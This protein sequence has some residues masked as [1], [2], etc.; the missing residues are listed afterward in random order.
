VTYALLGLRE[1]KQAEDERRCWALTT[2]P[3]ITMKLVFVILLTFVPATA[4]TLRQDADRAGVF[5]SAAVRPSQFNEVAYASTLAREFNMLEPEN[6]LKWSALRPDEKTF[7]F[8]Q[9]DQAVGF[10]RVHGMKVRGHTLVWGWWNPAWLT[11]HP[12]SPQQLSALLQEHITRVMT[13]YRGQIYAWDVLNEAIDERGHLRSSLWYDKPGIGLAGQTTAY[14][15]QVFRWAHAAD[16]SALLFYNDGGGETVNPKSDAMYAMVK[17]FK[18][19]GVPIHGV[20]LQMHIID[21]LNVD[22]P[23]I[24]ANIA[25]FTALGVQVHITELD[26]A[27]PTK[28]DGNVRDGADLSRQ[29]EI[30]RRIAE[31]CFSHPGCTT[32]QTWGFTDKYSWIRSRTKGDKGAALLFDRNYKPKP[33]FYALKEALAIRKSKTAISPLLQNSSGTC[34]VIPETPCK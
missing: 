31:A 25:R 4:Q 15:E 24:A 29:A 30:F 12:Y 7:D 16:P 28:A 27:L 22:F 17:D 1:Q 9:A 23:G 13:R 26:V 33:A 20:G 11:D 19:R 32:I 18:Q 10:A 3:L 14:I 5:I 21:N 8:T 6:D 2:A 34:D